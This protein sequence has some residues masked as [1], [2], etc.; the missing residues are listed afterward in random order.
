MML[1]YTPGFLK[2]PDEIFKELWNELAW[3]RRGETPRREYYSNDIDV[4]YVYGKGAG[5]RE[6]FPQP[7]HPRMREIQ[8]QLEAFTGTRFEV[9]FLNG[10]DDQRDSLSW[11]A[12][13][14]PEMDDDR[15]IAILSLGAERELWVCPQADTKDVT[16]QKLGNGSLCLMPPGMQDTH[17]HR[18][19]KAGFV[20]TPR[21]SLTFRGYKTVA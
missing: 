5:Q 15:P 3:Q 21:V 11:H 9:C 19:P 6:Y 12:D 2:N 1:Q 4:P 10:Y 17:F 20:C 13:D 16:K 18:I 8:R 7:W 14:S